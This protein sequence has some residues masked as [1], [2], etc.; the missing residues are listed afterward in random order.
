[1]DMSITNRKLNRSTSIPPTRLSP[2]N[3][4]SSRFYPG[5]YWNSFDGLQTCTSTASDLD[6]RTDSLGY[7]YFL[8]I[9][10]LQFFP[11]FS[12]ISPGVVIL[13]LVIILALTAIKDGYEDVKRHQADKRVNYSTVR[14][15]SGGWENPNKTVKKHT[16]FLRHV[17]P[18]QYDAAGIILASKRALKPGSDVNREVL[19]HHD[20]EV[21][22]DYDLGEEPSEELDRPHWKPTLS[23]DV[24]V[25]D[26][27]KILDNES[28][29]AD[30]LIC[31]TSEDDNVAFV[32]TKNLDGEANLKSR[33]AVQALTELRNAKECA[34]PDN[35]FHIRCDRPEVDMYRLN[36]TVSINGDEYPVDSTM[37][38]LRGTVLKNTGWVIGIVLFTGL[39]TKIVLNSGGTPSKRSRVERQ[40]NPQVCVSS[41]I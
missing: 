14:V 30:I 13:P 10:I 33:H 29:P 12:T 39:D 5:I 34:N 4:P 36:A 8:F 15:L 18:R 1:M 27:V 25:G 37:T 23:E 20:P 31:A 28:F 35:A 19:P 41:L 6:Q 22:F 11:P 24:R 7:R 32:E 16:S 2:Q 38:L 3:I 26:F 17:L 40:M 9:S 21:E